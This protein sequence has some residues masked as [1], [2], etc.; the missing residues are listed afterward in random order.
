MTHGRDCYAC[1]VQVPVRIRPHIVG[2][3]GAVGAVLVACAVGGTSDDAQIA[4]DGDDAGSGDPLDAQTA[5]FTPPDSGGPARPDEPTD[6]GAHGRDARDDAPRDAGNNPASC[7]VSNTCPL[8]IDL[9]KV[10]G[11]TDSAGVAPTAGGI[12]AKW[13]SV[14][15]TEDDSN[16]LFGKKQGLKA[17]LVSPPGVNFDLYLYVN[18]AADAVECTTARGQSTNATG[19]SDSASI[20]WGEG[21]SPN[22][23]SDTRTVSIEIRYV[24]GACDANSKW[25]LTLKGNP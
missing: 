14:R 3:A 25:T 4:T 13:L 8:A 1:G 9:G 19:P 23:L 20:K 16:F 2:L 17:D 22:G 10:S 7:M 18:E 24:S 5:P 15:V 12:T 6:A 21:A 11:D